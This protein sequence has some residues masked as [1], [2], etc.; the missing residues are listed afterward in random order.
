[1]DL[2]SVKFD[3]SRKGLSAKDIHLNIAHTLGPDAVGHSIVTLDVGDATC[4]GPM[5]PETAP[6][7]DREPDDI[8]RMILVP[9][10]GQPFAS[11]RELARLI[12]VSR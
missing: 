1:M 9:L 7:N 12:H 10:S 3:L 11:V 2:R 4:L 5:N 8:D 6:D